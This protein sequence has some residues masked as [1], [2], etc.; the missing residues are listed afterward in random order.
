M[1]LQRYIYT[2]I[3]STEVLCWGGYSTVNRQNMS[4]SSIPYPKIKITRMIKLSRRSQ[5]KKAL[6][7]V[8][9]IYIQNEVVCFTKNS[10]IIIILPKT[11]LI[12]EN[13]HSILPKVNCEINSDMQLTNN[14]NSAVKWLHHTDYLSTSLQLFLGCP[15]NSTLWLNL[16]CLLMNTNNL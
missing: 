15:F 4:C 9:L 13:L 8:H 6:H 7:K 3:Y 10:Q 12:M 2:T 16:I 1:W 14:C 5:R 11:S